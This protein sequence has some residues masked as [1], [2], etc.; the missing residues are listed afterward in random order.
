MWLALRLEHW[1]LDYRGDNHNP[2]ALVVQTIAQ[3]QRV[4][5]AGTQAMR[6]GVRCGMTL[7]DAR[8]RLTHVTTCERNTAA[9][10]AALKRLAGWAWR[11][12]DRIHWAVAG[13]DSQC[14]RLV[15]EIGASLR[16]FGGRRA[17]LARIRDDL[18]AFG[19]RYQAGVGD[20]PQ[21]ALAFARTGRARQQR[22]RHHAPDQG[23]A[24]LPIASLDLPS[25]A[26]ASLSASGLQRT[27]ELLAL[28]PATLVRRHGKAVLDYLEQLRGRRPHGLSL[29]RLPTRYTTRHEL[30][31]AVET[32]QGLVFVLRRVFLELA[33]FLRG[34]DSAIQTLQVTLTHERELA[35]RLVLR[36]S[37]PSCDAH[38][39]ER[40][41][42][43]RLARLTLDAPVVDIGVASD[44]LRRHE[45]AQHAFWPQPDNTRDDVWPAVLDRLR[46]RL[47]HKAVTWLAAAADHRP[48]QATVAVD[49][50][51][52]SGVTTTDQPPRPLWMLASPQPI[53]E[54][55]TWISGPERIETG[56]WQA[57]IRRDYYR[58][59]DRH[60]RLLWVFQ[61]LEAACTGQQRYYLHGLFG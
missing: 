29:Y 34:A 10:V 17:L 28:P 59:L 40:V 8:M 49:Q 61:D 41:A 48:E 57:G 58:A 60:G 19:Y 11:Y 45:H 21:A 9:E 25:A 53:E 1:A 13:P 39:L 37:A 7:A 55:L 23:L 27:G 14:S 52:A 26:A 12:S 16:L 6:A 18:K 47:G 44:R 43:E 33:A 36:L 30:S 15:L 54:S 46:A 42:H 31:G 22:P 32:T 3:R 51:P 35:T 56:W 2:S 38:H 24:G 50:P 5:A 4:V 20:S